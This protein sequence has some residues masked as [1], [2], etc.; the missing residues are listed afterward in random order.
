[1][2]RLGDIQISLMPQTKLPDDHPAKRLGDERAGLGVEFVLE[3]DDV[4]AA[5][6]R[7]LAEGW[8]V[9]APLTERPWGTRDFRVIDPDGLYIR[10]NPVTV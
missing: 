3:V 8:P 1:V 2:Y 9:A 10:V 4:D 5:Y 7:V 6:A